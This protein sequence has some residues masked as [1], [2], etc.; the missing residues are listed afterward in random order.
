MARFVAKNGYL[1][2]MWHHEIG[3]CAKKYEY[4]YEFNDYYNCEGLHDHLKR[5]KN[6]HFA[7]SRVFVYQS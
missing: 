5:T 4:H 7:L 2:K 6:L 3:L 1:A